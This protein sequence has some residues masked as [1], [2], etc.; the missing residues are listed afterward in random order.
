MVTKLIAL[1]YGLSMACKHADVAQAEF[2]VTY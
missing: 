2:S 1:G